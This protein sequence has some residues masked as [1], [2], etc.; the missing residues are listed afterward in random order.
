MSAGKSFTI[1]VKGTA[2]VLTSECGI[3]QAYKPDPKVPHPK[4]ENFIGI[5]DTGAT[6]LVINQNV[7]D[8]LGLK[9][10]KT[11]T[12]YHAQGQTEAETFAINLLLPNGVGF[13]FI[14]AVKGKI[15]GADLLIGMDVIT[16][17]DFTITNMNGETVMSFR[18]PSMH[19]VDYTAP[20]EAPKPKPKP[21]PYNGIGRNDPCP[22]GQ[23]KKF[24]HC[25]GK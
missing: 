24:K 20:D 3:C 8:K 10:Y 14:Q 17:G 7:V 19:Q 9:P 2:R 4:V 23:G 13:S 21:S 15:E 18:I 6:G 5:W 12:V 1:R 11:T 25:H 22:C 16:Q